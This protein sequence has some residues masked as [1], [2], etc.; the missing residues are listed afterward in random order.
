M[1]CVKQIKV[2]SVTLL[3]MGRPKNLSAAVITLEH[4]CL[5]LYPVYEA[6]RKPGAE[7]IIDIHHRYT[8]GARIEHAQERGQT[9]KTR[10]I[11]DAGRHGNDR[12]ID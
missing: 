4:S 3:R 12:F 11:A 9:V 6:R 5:Y 1:A 10:S 7:A 8:G 2:N